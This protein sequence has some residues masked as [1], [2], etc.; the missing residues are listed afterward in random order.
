MD[1]THYPFYYAFAARGVLFVSLDATT[2]GLLSREHMDWL[3][4]LL[5]KHGGDYAQRIAFSHLPLWP[6]AQRRERD[7]IGDPKLEQL[8]RKAG[9]RLYLSGHHHAF[10]PGH[11]DGIHHVSQSCLGAGPRKL[12]GTSA[13]SPRSFTLIEF[14]QRRLRLAAFQSPDFTRP[15][16][17][18]TLPEQIRS[19]ATT[20]TR[21]DLV[22]DTLDRLRAETG[23][24]P[25]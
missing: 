7:F 3:G 2:V 11:K 16:D 21:A 19:Q 6:F 25:E 14:D 20:L 5:D 24:I 23:A 8:L 18:A 1:D 10:Y 4:D 12:I 22:D 17:W 15:I 9:V 13:R